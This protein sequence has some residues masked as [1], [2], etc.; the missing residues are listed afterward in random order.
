MTVDF[1]DPE[2]RIGDCCSDGYIRARYRWQDGHF[3]EEGQ[4][5]RGK[6]YLHAAQ[7]RFREYR[8]KNAYRGV[9]ARPIITK[10]FRG[11]RTRIRE[12]AKSDVEFAGHYTVPRWGCGTECNAFVV[13]DSIGGK[14]YDGFGVAGLRSAGSNNTEATMG[15]HEWSSTPTVV[16]SKS[17]AALTKRIVVSTITKWSTRRA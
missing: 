9:P 1:A 12:G 13:V 3:V 2:K 16:C 15:Y 5:E 11:F 14:V 17:T 6:I 4:R 8:V 10:E 7:P